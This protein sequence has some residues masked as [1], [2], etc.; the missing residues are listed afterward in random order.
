MVGETVKGLRGL[1]I[2]F[3]AGGYYLGGSAC[4][5]L[6][7]FFVCQHRWRLAYYI[8]TALILLVTAVQF[9]RIRPPCAQMKS[10][11]NLSVYSSFIRIMKVRNVFISSMS[12]FSADIGLFAAAAWL[13]AFFLSFIGLDAASAGIAL[14]LLMLRG[15]VSSPVVGAV[16]HRI[17]RRWVVCISGITSAAISIPLLT[18]QYSFWLSIGYSLVLGFLLLRAWNLLITIAQESADKGAITSVT[19]ITQTLGVV[20]SA[21]GPVIAGN[22]IRI[23]GISQALIYSITLPAVIYGVLALGGV[24]TRRK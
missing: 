9:V 6:V 20:G 13:P 11:Q 22:L 17:R 12:I 10:G 8:T 18:T 7:G 14:G 21:A 16:S 2:G 19:G 23:F 15:L 4:S 3:A 1:A 5:I 24:E